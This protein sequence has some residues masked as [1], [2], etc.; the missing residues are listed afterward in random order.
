MPWFEGTHSDTFTVPNAI[1]STRHHF[2]DLS[3]IAAH[4]EG[5][6]SHEIDGTTLHFVLA[7]QDHGVVKFQGDYRCTYTLDGDT[8]SW[9][10]AGGNTD[11]SGEIRFRAVDGGTEVSYTET[12]KVDLDLA[13]PM[14]M[15]L[16]PVMGPML[17]HEI[18]G[19]VKRMTR[20][21][22]S[23]APS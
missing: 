11:Q 10:S 18:K 16:K 14:A 5:L 13:A 8:L 1:D 17:V 7:L 21:L 19:F 20:S 4:T 12:V 2:S 23:Q 22:K 6:S 15:M 3:T 9:C